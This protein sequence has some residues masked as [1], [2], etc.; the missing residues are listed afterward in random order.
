[1]RLVKS[2]VSKIFRFVGLEVNVVDGSIVSISRVRNRQ[3]KEAQLAISQLIES[4]SLIAS[5]LEDEK[6]SNQKRA[7]QIT[8]LLGI[9]KSFPEYT[10]EAIGLYSGINGQLAQ[11]FLALCVSK[12]KS[13]GFF[14]EF[15][16]TNGLD[17][18]NTYLLEKRFA[19]SGILAEPG[20]IWHTELESNRTCSI[21]RSAVWSESG[22]KLNFTEA[23]VPELS[24]ISKFK[25]TDFH[26]RTGREYEV[27]TISLMDLLKKY[28]A[29]KKIDFMSVDTEG[30]EFEILSCLDFSEYSFSF[31]CVEHNF[32]PSRDAVRELMNANGYLRILEEYSQFDDWYIN[33][34][35][36]SSLLN[37]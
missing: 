4:K 20:Q 30:S 26:A 36:K 14:V 16:A 35:A 28:N 18:S 32:G 12:F 24:T 23:S 10:D 27:S 22:I 33:Q 29:P 31:I 25:E 17:L 15:G 37:V 6:L 21:E 11:D 19:W 34:S 9:L 8:G 2:F 3:L 13:K 7:Q 5:R 1:M